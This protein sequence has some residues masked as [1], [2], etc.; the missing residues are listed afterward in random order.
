VE[1]L[2]GTVVNR[3]MVGNA[4]TEDM[5]VPDGV[6]DIPTDA[7][8]L[9]PGKRLTE[10]GQ[11]KRALIVAGQEEPPESERELGDDAPRRLCVPLSG[12]VTTCHVN[13]AE[14]LLPEYFPVVQIPGTLPVAAQRPVGQPVVHRIS[15]QN[16][17]VA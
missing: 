11:P 14:R 6:M 3:L 15:Q 13:G 2:Q 12:G 4:V 10:A 7:A 5:N 9:D 8:A 17:Q 16:L 1:F